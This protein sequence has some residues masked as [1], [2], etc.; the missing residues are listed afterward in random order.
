MKI[1]Q[2]LKRPLII[3]S[4]TIM[5]TG[6]MLLSVF[7]LSCRVSV[8]G[9]EIIGT[10]VKMPVLETFKVLDSSHL[11][12]SFSEEVNLL[13]GGVSSNPLQNIKEDHIDVSYELSQDK[14]T[15]LVIF[16]K[17]TETGRDYIFTGEVENKTGSTLTFSYGFTGFN[18]RVPALLLTEIADG[19]WSRKGKP[20][21][22]E[23]IEFYA[24]SS[25]NLAGLRVVSVTDGQEAAFCFPDFEITKGDY[26][27]VHYRN[28]STEAELCISETGGNRSACTALWSSPDAWDFYADRTEAVFGATQDVVYLENT[29]DNSILQAVVYT[30]KDKNEWTKDLYSEAAELCVQ[31]NTWGPDST[32]ENAV[33][34]QTSATL[35]RTNKEDLIKAF[36]N[37]ELEYPFP[38]KADEWIRVSQSLLTPGK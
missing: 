15:V 13:S 17:N 10:D 6:F 11:S 2:K 33:H 9:L 20:T 23:F 14:K 36:E 21:L 16:D 29:G 7:P 34:F 8:S 5:L 3:I 26:I 37:G 19:T 27:T 1:F 4:E 18:D 38:S 28:N 22:Y 24:L 25:G 12:I 31:S 32:I 35:Q 30:Q